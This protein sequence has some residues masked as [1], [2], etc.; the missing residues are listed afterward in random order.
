MLK[1]RL[2]RKN[3]AATIK[4]QFFKPPAIKNK[5]WGEA[6]AERHKKNQSKTSKNKAHRQK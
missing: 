1:K 2:H 6:L 3:R 5:F 4:Q